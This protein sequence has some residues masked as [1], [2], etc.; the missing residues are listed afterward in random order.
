MSWLEDPAGRLHRTRLNEKSQGLTNVGLLRIS[1]SV[2][3]Y[4]Y[5]VLS[6]QVSVRFRIIGS[7]ASALTDIKRYQETLKLRIK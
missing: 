5:L 3:A 1:E 2:R 4:A 7:T 6:S